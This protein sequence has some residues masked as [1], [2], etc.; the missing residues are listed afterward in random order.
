MIVSLKTL[1][2]YM[3]Y[4]KNTMNTSITNGIIEGI[5]NKIKVIKRIAF[6][7][8]NFDNLKKRFLIINGILNLQSN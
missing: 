7:Y 6:G 8:R 4:I 2:K 5:N 1:R 3:K